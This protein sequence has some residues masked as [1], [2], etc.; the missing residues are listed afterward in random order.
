MSVAV[1]LRVVIYWNWL[2]TVKVGPVGRGF[3]VRLVVIALL[4]V[5][6]VT[7]NSG[8]NRFDGDSRV[9]REFVMENGSDGAFLLFV[10]VPL[11]LRGA[12]PV[13]GSL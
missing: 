7:G 5:Y 1:S 2:G 13:L 11:Y 10:V 8:G 3:P 4:M 12:V 9:S 6:S